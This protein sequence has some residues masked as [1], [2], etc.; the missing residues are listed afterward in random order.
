M[1]NNYRT[2]LRQNCGIELYRIVLF[3]VERYSWASDKAS[4]WILISSRLLLA[5][6]RALR[7]FSPLI[8]C[9]FNKLV[10]VIMCH[11]S[12]CQGHF[13]Y[14]EVAACSSWCGTVYTV[15]KQSLNRNI[16]VRLAS[17]VW[18]IRHRLMVQ[19]TSNFVLYS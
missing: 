11:L 9:H 13:L 12:R 7:I 16:T 19:W 10:F 18:W 8:V 3:F 4:Q 14:S 5:C 15:V 1:F 2:L 17:C 6:V